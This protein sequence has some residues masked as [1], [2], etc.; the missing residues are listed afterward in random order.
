MLGWLWSRLTA[1]AQIRLL[2]W[3]LP[4]ATGVALKSRKKKKKKRI[5]RHI[6]KEKEEKWWWGG[7]KRKKTNKQ[8]AIHLLHRFIVIGHIIFK[9]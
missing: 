3:E 5:T 8:N 4:Y 9:N 7:T 2:A 6:K 1:E